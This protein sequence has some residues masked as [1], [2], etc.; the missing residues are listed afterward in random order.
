MIR[1]RYHYD[2]VA[3]C[4]E[5]IAELYSF[6][7]IARAK[8]AQ[9]KALQPGQS[10]LY[11][12]VGAGED[13]VLAAERGASL[14][15]LDLSGAMLARLSARLEARS[16]KAELLEGDILD[17]APGD[18]Y[19]VVVANFVLNVFSEATVAVVLKHLATL[20]APG[21]K[22]LI[23]DFAPPSKSAAGRA[24]YATYYRPIN[25]AAWMLRLCALHPIYNYPD[26][27]EDAGLTL[28]VRSPFALWRGGKSGG[29][30]AFY[31]S[32]V[33]VRAGTV[34]KPEG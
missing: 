1:T 21:G 34:V 5:W 3:W 6:G 23:A 26:Y 20:L 14:T 11:V 22:I 24:L 31:E 15:C 33:A 27:F 19:D 9:T 2:R 18:T 8:A 25:W 10:V 30:P 32:L 17:Y 28:A 4:Y 7:A 29:G 12:G 13:A 16:L